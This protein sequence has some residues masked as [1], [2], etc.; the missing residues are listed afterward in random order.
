MASISS[1]IRAKEAPQP[2]AQLNS[3]E[4][5]F[6]LTLIKNS[7]FKGKSLEVVYGTVVKLQHQ[8]IALQNKQE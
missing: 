8:Y 4:I 5:E 3:S 1:L 7:N 2:V 6:L